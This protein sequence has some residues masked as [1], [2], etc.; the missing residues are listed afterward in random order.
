M[1]RPSG[2]VR[3]AAP[4]RPAARGT[5]RAVR[6][7]SPSW[8]RREPPARRSSAAI[9]VVTGVALG[10]LGVGRGLEAARVGPGIEVGHRIHHAAAEL[11]KARAAADDALFL[12]R[13]WRQA[14]VFSGFVVG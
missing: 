14:Q 9:A 1:D 2:L 4:C 12:Q 7:P 10:V 11:A 13:A 6:A 8:T 3:R 5:G